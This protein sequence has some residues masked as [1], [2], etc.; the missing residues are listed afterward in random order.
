MLHLRLY[1]L[2]MLL[3]FLVGCHSGNST[4]SEAVRPTAFKMR[5]TPHQ[6]L[7]EFKAERNPDSP[8]LG[9][10]G[11]IGLQMDSEGKESHYGITN[12]AGVDRLI[13]RCTESGMDRI[14]A[15]IMFQWT[16]STLLGPIPIE[17]MPESADKLFGYAV[18]AAHKHN[19]EFY[20]DIPVFGRRTRDEAFVCAHQGVFTKSVSGEI[21]QE[22]FSPASPLVRAYRIAVILEAL[23]QYPVDGI[24]LDFI[25]WPGGGPDLLNS[26]SP[27]GYEEPMLSCFRKQ[28]NLADDY[29]PSPDDPRFIQVRADMI[30]LFI[31]E[32]R[33]ALAQNNIDL[34]IGVYNSNSAG[35]LASLQHV[36]QDWAAW[37]EQELVDEHHP[38]FY[39]DSK[40][41]LTRSL[42]TLV[43]VKRPASKVFGPIFLDGPGDKSDESI[44]D[45][46]QRMIQ[47]GCD[48]IWFC[49]ATQIENYDL[50]P[51]VKAIDGYSIQSIRERESDPYHENLVI[52][53]PFEN[54]TNGWTINTPATSRNSYVNDAGH[55]VITQARDRHIT[56]KQVVHHIAH[57]VF[58]PRSLAVVFDSLAR[59]DGSDAVARV[60]LVLKYSDGHLSTRRYKPGN[61]GHELSDW[62]SI[63][64]RFS[65]EY[66]ERYLKR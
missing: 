8:I 61:L 9:F 21:K 58:A 59:L 33:E 64:D 43:K 19:I 35:R 51:T 13:K 17:P 55:L 27:W 38:M 1:T 12:E 25:R 44:Q 48:G 31:K 11:G 3:I 5:I 20:L 14:Y 60:D 54:G 53:G 4:E 18:E 30:T 16:P 47:V 62:S 49:L 41:R 57:P 10:Y 56:C 26:A 34:P 15:N 29:A 50:W 42:S 32:L 28:Y 24:Q 22:Y 65:V 45:S 46:A 52:N 6:G 63:E 66:G 2:V 36:C 39:M 23:S 37:E 7:G 40:A